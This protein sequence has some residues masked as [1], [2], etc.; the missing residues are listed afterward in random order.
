MATS[1]PSGL[2]NFTNP[3]GT[4]TLDSATVPHA[5][6]HANANDAI[7]AI[8]TELGTNP[9]GSSATV[10]AR[11]DTLDTTV[12]AKAPLASPTFTGTPAA[13]TAAADTNTT[14]VAT[15]AYVVGQ[16]YAK[17]ASPTFTGTPLST[18]AT[19]DTNTTQIATTAYVVGQ[20]YAKL[21]SPT[22]TGTPTL[23]TGTI[24]TTQTALDSTTAVAT[25]AFVTTADNLKANLASPTFTGTPLSTTAA[26][27]TNTT[28]IATTA[29]V[30]GQAS[31]A[32]PLVD[33]VATVGTSL[34]YAR[35][36]HIHPTDTT[37][38]PIA[39]PTFT[40]TVNVPAT[41][42][43]SAGLDFPT[44][45]LL[46]TQNGGT[47]EYDGSVFYATPNVNTASNVSYAGR[48]VIPASQYVVLNANVNLN[49]TAVTAQAMFASA[50][51]PL[52]A[53]SLA[54]APATTYMV[55]SVI[56][57]TKGAT[58]VTVTFS[59]PAGGSTTF[60]ASALE[61]QYV[62]A[63]ANT[64]TA[65]LMSYGSATTGSPAITC[66]TAN[67]G[68]AAAIFVKG[69]V[70]INA[71]TSGTGTVIPSITFSAAT[72]ATPAILRESYIR[73]TP[74]GTNAQVAVGAWA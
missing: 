11:L 49:A 62:S 44:G 19:A 34:K 66:V 67:T 48:G 10:K 57:L 23:P 43:G 41:A 51:A 7:E 12:S 33:G 54:V 56:Y 46:T 8:E 15:T 50:T 16:A 20:G 40:G 4:D 27:D 13:P 60:T 42:T 3:T 29:F 18:T 45:T 2:D 53:G 22:F 71:S 36:G 28:Q 32:T 47:V 70:K 63:A 37:R 14:Q 65:P 31:S 25:T 59:L 38:A 52:T 17:L 21:A 55:E 39:S 72:G 69:V 61:C 64:P 9:K 6:Q 26:A 68:T 1:Y 73:F 58:S 35:E 5:T 30:V 74:I 24:A